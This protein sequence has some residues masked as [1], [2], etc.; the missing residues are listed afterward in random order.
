[1]KSYLLTRTSSRECPNRRLHEERGIRDKTMHIAAP[2]VTI[3][4]VFPWHSVDRQQIHIVEHPWII[5]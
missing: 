3:Y 2:K 4:S 5:T 1:M